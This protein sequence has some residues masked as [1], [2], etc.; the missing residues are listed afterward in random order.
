[1]VITIRSSSTKAEIAAALKKLH[2]LKITARSK[3]KKT[4]DTHRLLR[5][6]KT[7]AGPFTITKKMEK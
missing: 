3:S 5:C 1:M 4:F 7:K 2:L 6:Y